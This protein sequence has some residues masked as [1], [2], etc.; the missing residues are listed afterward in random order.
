MEGQPPSKLDERMEGQPP[1]KRTRLSDRDEFSLDLVSSCHLNALTV[2]SD[3]VKIASR[4]NRNDRP[5]L[6]TLRRYAHNQL[7]SY[8]RAVTPCGPVGST[9]QV[10]LGAEQLTVEFASPFAVL[11][12]ASELNPVYG[13]FIAAHCPQCS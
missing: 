3:S 5:K 8:L 2:L 6:R 12:R 10:A 7:H 4:D 1:S 9:F 13:A 11:R